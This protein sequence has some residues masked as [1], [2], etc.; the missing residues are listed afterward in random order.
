MIKRIYY[1][2]FD[3]S[4][5]IFRV[6]FFQKTLI[7][8]GKPLDLVVVK[9]IP[10]RKTNDAILLLNWEQATQ[11]G[12]KNIIRI[13]ALGEIVWEINSK[14]CFNNC[15]IWKKILFADYNY[16]TFAIDIETGENKGLVP[17]T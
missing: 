14:Y 3:G 16:E 13:N 17:R 1:S 5:F 4:L 12:K 7:W 2:I 6:S 15:F 9:V 11:Q 10:L 8:K